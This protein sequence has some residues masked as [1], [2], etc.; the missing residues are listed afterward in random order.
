LIRVVLGRWLII[1]VLGR[2]LIIVVLGRW[3]IV[4]FGR[5]L[6]V[7]SRR[8]IG[9]HLDGWLIAL[10]RRLIAIVLIR[11]LIVRHCHFFHLFSHHSSSFLACCAKIR[12]VDF[13]LVAARKY[14]PQLGLN[15]L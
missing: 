5:R 8:L 9:T 3:L 2:W 13:F 12:S 14:A 6:I 7:L 1:V 4:V 11:I 15:S 10:G